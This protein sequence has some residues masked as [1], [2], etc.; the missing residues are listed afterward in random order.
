MP[1]DIRKL[2]TISEILIIFGALLIMLYAG[3]AWGV[4]TIADY[5]LISITAF[6]GAVFLA[7]GLGGFIYA[8]VYQRPPTPAPPE[9]TVVKPGIA[10]P[11]GPR[12]SY[13]LVFPDGSILKVEGKQYKDLNPHDLSSKA[14]S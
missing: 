1:V 4:W 5:V 11:Y 14:S 12:I 2:E 9:E 6:L 10:M 13:S 8:N 3:Q 7:V